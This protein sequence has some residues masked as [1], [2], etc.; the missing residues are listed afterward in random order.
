L[1]FYGLGLEDFSFHV[2]QPYRHRRC[3]DGEPVI[4]REYGLSFLLLSVQ[5][6]MES[7][8]PWVFDG[9]ERFA[10]GTW[11]RRRLHLIS[12]WKLEVI[13]DSLCFDCCSWA[14][15]L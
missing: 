14:N 13:S 12:L 8:S 11:F 1:T 4:P 10:F 5:I 9:R 6:E 7:V 3:S 2:R 15:L